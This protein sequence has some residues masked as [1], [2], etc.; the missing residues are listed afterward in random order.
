MKKRFYSLDYLKNFEHK[1][2]A[3]IS[4]RFDDMYEL[5]LQYVDGKTGNTRN[6]ETNKSV[7]DFIDDNGVIC[8]DLLEESVLK[9]HKS[10]TSAK[11]DS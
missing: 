7:A 1:Y 10:L 11:K 6:A 9:L 4:F 2:L 8:M 3:N 5:S